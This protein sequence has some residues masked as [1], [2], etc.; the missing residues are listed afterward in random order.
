MKITRHTELEVF[1]RAF[2]AAMRVFELTQKFPREEMYSLTDQIRR[3]SRSVAANITE[4]W[5][6]RRY[7]GAFVSKLS[8][9]DTEAAE[10][11]TW[12]QFAF[13]CGY[14]KQTDLQAMEEEYEIILR[15]LVAMMANAGKWTL[16][17]E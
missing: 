10:T 4:A 11:Q 3:S 9:A 5:R 15:M 7:E 8:D 16:S 13:R 2:E 14:L 17:R 12:L 1:Q 6:K